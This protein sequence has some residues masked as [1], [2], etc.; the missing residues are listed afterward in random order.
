[1]IIVFL[2]IGAVVNVAV[3]WGC[4]LW[5]SAG[6]DDEP[7][8]ARRHYGPEHEPIRRWEVNTFNRAG[9]TLIVSY[10]YRNSNDSPD[11]DAAPALLMPEWADLPQEPYFAIHSTNEYV[12]F[13]ARGW[14]LISLWC[15]RE[16]LGL[17]EPTH[18][19]EGGI[20]TG[21]PQ[22][23]NGPLVIWFRP[24]LPLRP[25]WR[26]FAANTVFYAL[27]LWL[28]IRGPFVLRRMIRRR[29]GRCPNCGYPVGTS[30]VCTECS[31]ALAPHD[32][33]TG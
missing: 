21:L 29:R 24:A 5:V 12:I 14:P 16:F 23:Q 18:R 22:F 33:I 11:T 26:N 10:R 20:E 9:S 13:D 25:I 30:A 3:A 17:L 15:E 1:M 27:I 7:D 28:A 2:L 31:T 6:L 19:V 8:W 4:A 32:T